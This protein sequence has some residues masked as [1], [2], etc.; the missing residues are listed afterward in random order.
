MCEGIGF[1]RTRT[2]NNEERFEIGILARN[3]LLGRMA[4]QP[5]ARS[6]M[7]TWTAADSTIK[8]PEVPTIEV[9]AGDALRLSSKTLRASQAA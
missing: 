7:L 6:C 3:R 5:P 8:I 9:P 1:A 2:S 4:M